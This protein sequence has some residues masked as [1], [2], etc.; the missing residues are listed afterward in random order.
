MPSR[1]PS[2]MRRCEPLVD[3]QGGEL[4]A[5]VAVST[6]PSNSAMKWCSGSYFAPCSAAPEV[7]AS[8]RRSWMRSSAAATCS[9][10]MRC[11]GRI[12]P[13]WTIA[14]VRP[15]STASLRNTELRTWRAAGE[16]PNET[17]D[18]PSVVPQPGTR[19]LDPFDRLE[20]RHRV[21]AQ[22]LLPGP[23]RE[24]EAVED[25]VL[26]L[27]PEVVDG[28]AGD[29]LAHLDLP[30]GGAGLSLLVDGEHHDRGAVALRQRQQHVGLGAAVLEVDRVD[31]GAAAEP[32]ERRL[33][34]VELGRVDDQRQRRLGRV[35]VDDRRPC[36]A[37][38]RG[39]RSRRR[40]RG[41][42]RPRGSATWPAR[43]C[44]P[45]P[46]RAAARGTPWSR[47]RSRA[48]RWPGT[49]C[50][51]RAVDGAVQRRERRPVLDGDRSSPCVRL[52]RSAPSVTAAGA[53]EPARTGLGE[54]GTV[55][56]PRRAARR[57]SA[58]ASTTAARCVGGRAAAA[59]DDRDAGLGHELA[60][61]GGQPRR[62]ERVDGLAVHERRDAG[63]RDHADRQARGPRQGPD[64]L[65]HVLRAGGAVHPQHVDGERVERGDGRRGFGPEQHRVDVL[66][67]RELHHERDAGAALDEDVVGGGDGGLDLQ[68]VEAGLD[69]QHVGAARRAARGPAGGSRPPSWRGR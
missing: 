42:A 8:P 3:R 41:R 60:L 59:T 58:T 18:T 43:P 28:D 53:N 44:R 65:A 62:V 16:R 45:S 4:L 19:G 21:A 46:R 55:E 39:R 66:L 61:R 48:R 25:Q 47:W 22:V 6:A 31:D 50:P 10:G 20:G 68:Q 36:R 35:A 17:F 69:E 63:V 57:R 15:R 2:T 27:E 51:A 67:D 30:V 49:R 40:R 14:E 7:P 1:S 34:D 13:G 23:E 24:G 54:L 33:D 37:P 52:A 12:L 11:S 5:V 26:R 32:H 38:R 64:V 56:R 9:S 29:P